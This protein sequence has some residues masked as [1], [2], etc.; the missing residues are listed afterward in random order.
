VKLP[1]VAHPEA[2]A[3]LNDALD[4]Y[5]AQRPGLGDD[6]LEAVLS[7]LEEGVP[8]TLPGVGPTK[9]MPLRRY[10]VTRFPYVVIVVVDEEPRIVA[11]AHQSRKPGYWLHRVAPSPRRRVARTG[12]PETGR[13]TARRRVRRLRKSDKA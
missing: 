11:I 7:A 6:F 10:L 4:W 13:G 5:E 8:L 12:R 9:G 2:E 1:F 3:E